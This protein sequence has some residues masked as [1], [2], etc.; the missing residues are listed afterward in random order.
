[1]KYPGL[2]LVQKYRVV[3]SSEIAIHCDNYE[4]E[5]KKLYQDAKYGMR[6]LK[7]LPRKSVEQRKVYKKE[8]NELDYKVK[9]I[10]EK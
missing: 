4:K 2:R 8:K 6:V 10:N 5:E 7:S 3:F 1:M 9:T